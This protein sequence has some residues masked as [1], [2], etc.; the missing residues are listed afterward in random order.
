MIN[1]KLSQIFCSEMEAKRLSHTEVEYF[2]NLWHNEP[3]LWN[4]SSASYSDGD[5]R[6]AAMSRI[7]PPLGL[8]VSNC[9]LLLVYC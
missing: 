6:K 4:S 1:S 3:S 2:I 9:G 5:V 8:D 7:S